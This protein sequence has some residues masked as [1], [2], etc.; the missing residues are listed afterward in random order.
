MAAFF[1]KIISMSYEATIVLGFILAAR[2]I[3]ELI[4]VPKKYCCLLWAIPFL[5][6]ILPF[7]IQSS[8]SLMPSKAVISTAQETVVV[9]PQVIA[10]GGNVTGTDTVNGLL[11]TVAD[12]A[13]N[14]ALD[15]MGLITLLWV[16]GILLFAS[17][18]VVSYMQLKAKLKCSMRLVDNVYAAD[19]IDTPFV[20][21]ILKPC[22]YIPS[23]TTKEEYRYVLAHEKMHLQRKDHLYKLAVF[24][25]LGLHWFNP[26]TWLAYLLLCKDMEMACDEAVMMQLGDDCKK[27]YAKALLDWSADKRLRGVPLAFSEGNVKGRIR[28][29]LRFKKPLIGISIVA[30][31]GI[32]VLAVCLLSNPADGDKSGDAST[33]NSSENGTDSILKYGAYKLVTDEEHSLA[34]IHIE[35]DLMSFSYHALS[36]YCPTGSYEVEGDMLTLTTREEK[37]YRFRI[38]GDCLIFVAEGSEPIPQFELEGVTDVTDGAV[39]RYVE[40]LTLPV[41]IEIT[42]PMLSADMDWGADGAILDYA[43]KTRVIFHGYFGLFVYDR[44]KQALVGAVDLEPIGCH[45]TQGDEACEVFVE[46]DGSKVYLS[47][48]T[49]NM[50]YVYDVEAMTLVM[51]PYDASRLKI[52][53]NVPRDGSGLVSEDGTIGQLKFVTGVGTERQEY[54]IFQN[55]LLDQSEQELEGLQGMLDSMEA[56]YG[57]NFAQDIM[58]NTWGMVVED[59]SRTGM[60][61]TIY[62]NSDKEIRFG[63]DFKL[64][65]QEDQEWVE[66]PYII[67]NWAFT[68]EAYP[69][70]ANRSRTE[71]VDWEWLYGELP[72]GIYLFK[73]T[74]SYKTDAEDWENVELGDTLNN[75]SEWEHVELG[76]MFS[77]PTLD[78]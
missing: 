14:I 46:A 39:F 16:V 7:S 8:L 28:N 48:L 57:E 63:S 32:V 33:G 30:V 18:G 47:S 64:F 50:M 54:F 70:D 31:V 24:L 42:I 71:T 58:S 49:S 15:K 3:M 2:L 1:T 38:D 19:Y 52:Q 9:M 62:N 26:F 43:D 36:S 56:D 25:I 10:V 44:E 41:D 55:L 22:I 76:V 73:K 35:E 45:Y 60:T 68:M 29:V 67:N 27:E 65:V 40:P 77:I 51:E 23:A 69:V 20:L 74:I 61:F 12:T 11:P 4:K 72:D 37:I 17:Y 53:E 75:S 13:K 6:M 34:G 21:G 78:T 5:R 59:L 66:V